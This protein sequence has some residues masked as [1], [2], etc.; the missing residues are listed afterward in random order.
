MPQT[1]LVAPHSVV[2]SD[3]TNGNSYP[4]VY[5]GAANSRRFEGIHVVA[6][7]PANSDV[8][9][10]FAIPPTLAAITNATFRNK[11]IAA[12]AAGA[13]KYIINYAVVAAGANYDTTAFTATGVQTATAAVSD[14]VLDTDTAITIAQGDAGK[15]LVVRLSFQ[16]LNWTLA[17]KS[18]WQPFLKIDVA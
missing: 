9:L 5:V 2:Y 16:T 11:L 13:A 12:A 1:A 3:L 18:A 10:L 15:L 17:V 7:L 6:S 8:D 14:G 4:G